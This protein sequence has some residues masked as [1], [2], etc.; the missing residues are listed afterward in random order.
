MDGDLDPMYPMID[1]VVTYVL[2]L[3]TYPVAIALYALDDPGKF[4]VWFVLGLMTLSLLVSWSPPIA[5]LWAALWLMPGTIICGAATLLPLP[6][7]VWSLFAP[8]RCAS[9]GSV[10]VCSALNA[11]LVFGVGWSWTRIRR[12][13]MRYG[14]FA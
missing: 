1:V 2:F 7:A 4:A 13:R 9:V 10:L 11:A 12:R 14:N 5:K 3:A 8:V 6:F